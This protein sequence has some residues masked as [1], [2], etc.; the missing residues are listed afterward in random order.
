MPTDSKPFDPREYPGVIDESIDDGQEKASPDFYAR[1]LVEAVRIV[2]Q[3]RKPET[4]ET[5]NRAGRSQRK[6]DAAAVAKLQQERR[7][8]QTSASTD[9]EDSEPQARITI[10][11]S[12]RCTTGNTNTS[13]TQAFPPMERAAR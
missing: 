9:A 11:F 8:A 10:E 1:N 5:I 2:A 7:T 13:H 4:S 12:C 6:W 3:Q